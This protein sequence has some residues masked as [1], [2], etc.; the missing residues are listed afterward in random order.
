[1]FDTNWRL[2][3]LREGTN[4][5]RTVEEYRTLEY[6]R[7]TAGW[8]LRR[9]EVPARARRP[10]RIRKILGWAGLGPPLPAESRPESGSHYV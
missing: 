6:P 2:R 4:Y 3:E 9:P 5:S 7:E 10:P 8:I 1:M